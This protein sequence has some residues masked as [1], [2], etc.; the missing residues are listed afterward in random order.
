MLS[1]CIANPVKANDDAPNVILLIVGLGCVGSALIGLGTVFGIAVNEAAHADKEKKLEDEKLIQQKKAKE[2]L[3]SLEKKYQL[4][5]ESVEKTGEVTAEVI[6]RVS[7]PYANDTAYYHY[8]YGQMVRA[9]LEKINS[10]K[11]YLSDT[12]QQEAEETEQFLNLLREKNAFYYKKD[13]ALEFAQKQKDDAA[14]HKR[15]LQIA[16]EKAK[17]EK[18]EHEKNSAIKSEQLMHELHE[19]ACTNHSVFLATIS[20]LEQKFNE[21]M[22]THGVRSIISQLTTINNKQNEL[23]DLMETMVAIGSQ[24]NQ[25]INEMKKEIEEIKKTQQKIMQRLENHDLTF[26]QFAIEFNDLKEVINRVKSILTAP[27]APM[28]E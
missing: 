28:R 12:E 20:R 27:S 17:Y 13:I 15:K 4:E 9:D 25:T 2:W 3:S 24:S 16:T 23:S 5:Y 18:E 1:L 21:N 11:D 7:L 22:D 8:Y 26:A 10:L 14:E 6:E 19:Q